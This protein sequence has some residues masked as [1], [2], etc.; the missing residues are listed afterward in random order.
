MIEGGQTLSL[1]ALFLVGMMGAGHCA[2]MCGGIISAL[3]FASK[4]KHSALLVFGY[5]LGRICSYAVAGALV[6]LLGYWGSAY[7]ALGPWLRIFAGLLLI[8]MGLYLA[9]WWRV[10]VRLETLGTYLWRWIQP[11]GKR[12]LPPTNLAQAL[13][14]GMVWG[15]LPCGLVYSALAYAATS[16]TPLQGAVLMAAFGLGTSPAMLIS[17]FF[18]ERARHLLQKKGV[19][20]TMAIVMIVF[21]VWTISVGVGHIQPSTEHHLAH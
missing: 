13:V 10:L 18:S 11:L 1:V 15:W 8:L 2:G 9:S 19:R 20:Q 17:G 12:L 5:N 4:G 21:G 14:L 6:A 3:G 7:L 16:E